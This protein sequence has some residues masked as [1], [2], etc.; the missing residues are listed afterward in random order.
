MTVLATPLPGVV[1]DP[2]GI[3]ASVTITSAS[4]PTPTVYSD[5]FGV[6]PVTM[7]ATISM[8]TVFFLPSPGPWVVNNNT[9]TLEGGEIGTVNLSS[10]P[11]QYVPSGNTSSGTSTTTVPGL[12]SGGVVDNYAAINAAMTSLSGAGGGIVSLPVGVFAVSQDVIPPANV[13]VQGVGR[14]QSENL[15]ATISPSGG[16][17]LVAM[18]TGTYSKAVCQLV[19]NGSGFRDICA[20][21]GM[22]APSALYVGGGGRAV[23]SHRNLWWGGTVASM[24]FDANSTDVFSF[25]DMLNQS[26]FTGTPSQGSSPAGLCFYAKSVDQ[27]ILGIQSYNGPW[28]IGVNENAG[29][30]VITHF[31]ISAAGKNQTAANQVSSVY[32]DGGS[33]AHFSNGTIDNG[34]SGNAGQITAHVYRHEGDI[35]FES[36]S[37][38]NGSPFSYPV[39]V[40]DN[41]H[42]PVGG[43]TAVNCP[44][45]GGT[46]FSVLISFTTSGTNPN[47]E[48]DL[49][50][51]QSG[52]LKGAA[53]TT[54][55]A[56]S[57]GADPTTWTSGSPG[58]L[59]V[60]ATTGFSATGGNANVACVSGVALFSYTGTGAG[61]LTGCVFLGAT[62]ATPGTI[63]T[64]NA[65][66][67]GTA[68]LWATGQPGKATGI[69]WNNVLQAELPTGGTAS[70]D[71]IATANPTQA[72]W[73]NSSNRITG[74]HAGINPNDAINVS[75]QLTTS[76]SA[77]TLAGAPAAP[78]IAL[79]T[80]DVIASN[81]APVA[82]WSNNS[83]KITG[84]QS[85]TNTNDVANIG[86]A[87][88][89]MY[90]GTATVTPSATINTFGTAVANNPD[91]GHTNIEPP[92]I[93]SM[94]STG[95]GSETVTVQVIAN[96]SDS[97]TGTL[98]QT[99]TTN[100]T[101]TITGATLTNLWKDN[102]R[103]TSFTVQA[104]SSIGSSTASVAVSSYSKQQ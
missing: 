42:D 100:T 78:T 38:Q 19:N 72:A 7:P 64:G 91:S 17:A 30:L 98:A 3:T 37:F 69:R 54:V 83:H 52:A 80:L 77:I 62:V 35:N 59:S 2:A 28:Q 8:A 94:V 75:Q 46:P 70:L 14:G 56:G 21:A 36:T 67:G 84:V 33:G 9:I 53:S 55:A 11:G 4:G 32:C 90:I 82:A 10:V 51:A 47:T 44:L 65:V 16:T 93:I 57:N 95:V 31:H 85:G 13:I 49:I 103:I 24:Y 63:A 71:Q 41:N 29:D 23:Q 73:S 79:A 40:D 87:I 86:Q 97:T 12:T 22:Y 74:V 99:I 15:P 60:A 58:T 27:R 66:Y 61:T 92:Q 68:V 104:K 48:L 101:T 34:Q 20:A 39:F 6:N 102:V 43:V 26:T 25:G 45:S 81:H 1:V 96:Y 88:T 76:D 5:M 89:T 50:P 18:S